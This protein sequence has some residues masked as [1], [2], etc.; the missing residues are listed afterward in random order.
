MISSG[1]PSKTSSSR[2]VLPASTIQYFKRAPDSITQSGKITAFSIIAPSRTFTLENNTLEIT[3]TQN[4]KEES[5]ITSEDLPILQLEKYK[6]LF[7]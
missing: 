5:D 2:T 4:Y 3:S 7:F 6:R 1:L